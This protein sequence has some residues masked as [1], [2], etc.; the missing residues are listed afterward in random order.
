MEVR[1]LFIRFFMVIRLRYIVYR[2]VNASIVFFNHY[3]NTALIEIN[4]SME[5]I[6]NLFMKCSP[7][8]YV[9]GLDRFRVIT[10]PLTKHLSHLDIEQSVTTT[11]PLSSLS[12]VG[13]I[14]LLMTKIATNGRLRNYYSCLTIFWILYKK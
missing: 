4:P 11:P 6:H 12:D 1:L 10:C 9:K 3:N 8:H 2:I 7:A 13:L 14:C 5:T